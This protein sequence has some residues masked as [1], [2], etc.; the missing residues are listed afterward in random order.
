MKKKILICGATGFI[1]K[2][3]ALNFCLNKT[4]KVFCT[5]NKKKPYFNKNINWIKIDLRK[6]NKLDR[7]T[8]DI[9]IIIQ[10]AA[11][12]SGVKAIIQKPYEHVTDNVILNSLL[13]ESAYRN[14]VKHFIFFS[15]SVMYQSSKKPLRESDF[16]PNNK[17]H[18]NYFG[19]AN[20]KLYIEKL[21]NFYSRIGITKFTCIRHSN[22]YGP[23]DKFDLQK[24]HFLAATIKKVFSKKEEIIVWGDGSE[25][26]DLLHVSDLINFVKLVIKNQKV[27]FRIYNCGYGK[28]FSI[29]ELISKIIFFSK[30]DKKLIFDKFKPTIK[31]FVCLNSGLAFRE[32]KWK[33]KINIDEGI[34]STIKWYNKNYN[35]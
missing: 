12:T 11:T 32:L 26:R 35:E 16:D 21:C 19:A 29:K 34:Q 25:R 28:S 9:D 31:T 7:V 14:K 4:Y 23:N 18:Q 3:I 6:R 30:K 17:I 24:G 5:Y 13:L 27:K 2:N 22:I 1:G 20:T 10:A 33:K 15:C 8:K